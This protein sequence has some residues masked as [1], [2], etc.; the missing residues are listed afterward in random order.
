M[1]VRKESWRRKW[2][3]NRTMAR[4]RGRRLKGL[5][6]EINVFLWLSN[7]IGT[8]VSLTIFFARNICCL[9]YGVFQYNAFACS[10]KVLTKYES[11]SG[12]LFRDPPSA[13]FNYENNRGKPSLIPP[14]TLSKSRVWHLDFGLCFPI[15]K[16]RLALRPNPKSLTGGIKSTLA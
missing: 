9:I 5:S 13:Y 2:W 4:G 12:T 7:L 14:K 6:H 1:K 10:Y 15:P 11:P 3:W 8:M 16:E